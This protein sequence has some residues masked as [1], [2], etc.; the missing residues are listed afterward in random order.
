MIFSRSRYKNTT[1]G[2]LTQVS[3]DGDKRSIS[4]WSMPCLS[5]IY[6]CVHMCSRNVEA[7]RVS[8]PVENMKT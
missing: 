8:N 7:M 6:A 3:M 4:Y 2:V 1:L 5:S